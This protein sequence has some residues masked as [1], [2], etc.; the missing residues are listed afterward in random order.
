MGWLLFWRSNRKCN[1][2]VALDSSCQKDN[3]SLGNFICQ[4]LHLLLPWCHQNNHG[5]NGKHQ[6]FNRVDLQS[7]IHTSNIL[8]CRIYVLW[9]QT[10][11][12]VCVFLSVWAQLHLQKCVCVYCK[13]W[14]HHS[15]QSFDMW[16][17][18]GEGKTETSLLIRPDSPCSPLPLT[19][20]NSDLT[21]TSQLSLYGIR[22]SAWV[23]VALPSSQNQCLRLIRLATHISITLCEQRR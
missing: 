3:A 1:V 8:Y 17:R 22:P 20:R 2:L 7:P 12:W 4:L 5:W 10:A 9:K 23:T 14:I 15:F 18:G 16:L 6:S 11:C 19:E 13:V 21:S